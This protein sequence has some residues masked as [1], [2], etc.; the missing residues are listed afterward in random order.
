VQWDVKHAYSLSYFRWLC[1]Q[2]QAPTPAAQPP[3]VAAKPQTAPKPQVAPKPHKGREAEAVE[4]A[5]A[6]AA[7]PQVVGDA[8][9]LALFP[10]CF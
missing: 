4:P 8:F 5:A 6:G 1:Q 10:I 7:A 3:P 9:R 2:K